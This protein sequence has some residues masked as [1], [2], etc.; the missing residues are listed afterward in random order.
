MGWGW[1]SWSSSPSSPSS[2]TPEAPATPPPPSP[3]NDKPGQGQ[4]KSLDLQEYQLQLMLLEQQNLKR[5]IK[6]RQ[7]EEARQGARLPSNSPV[8]LARPSS[9][10]P[11]EP[12]RTPREQFQRT[13][14]QLGLFFAGAGFLTASALISKR[15]VSRKMVDS[16]PKFYQ[17]SHHGPRPPP[18]APAEKSDDQLVAVEALGLATLNVFSFGVMLTGGLMFGFDISNV[19]ELRRKARSKLYGTN[20]VVDDAADQQVEE[21]IAEVLSRKDKKDG[22]AGPQKKDG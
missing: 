21:W 12:Q 9:P 6:L 1:F 7:E 14:K 20:G 18:R 19:E 10:P 22:E 17:P 8:T 16:I 5:L 2:K 4:A 15:A 3:N 13:A 11:P